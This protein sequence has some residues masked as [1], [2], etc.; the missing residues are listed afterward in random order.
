MPSAGS[1]ASRPVVEVHFDPSTDQASRGP[2]LRARI[3]DWVI[4]EIGSLRDASVIDLMAGPGLFG[5]DL[6]VRGATRYVGLDNDIDVVKAAS[7][8]HPTDDERVRVL[9]RDALV[10]KDDERGYCLALAL[11]EALNAFEDPEAFVLI[12]AAADRLKPGGHLVIDFRT[13]KSLER[14]PH[15]T[16]NLLPDHGFSHDGYVMRECGLAAGGRYY[17]Q[18]YHLLDHKSST[19]KTFYSFIKLRTIESVCAILNRAG[20]SVVSQSCVLTDL[21]SDVPES[22]DNIF[23]IANRT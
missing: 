7:K 23:V 3:L 13:P 2:T 4:A 20:L 16:R 19:I 11:Y 10:V 14:V 22:L 1:F 18:V 21:S 8:H 5:T 15:Y 9:H 17:G 12:R 6:V